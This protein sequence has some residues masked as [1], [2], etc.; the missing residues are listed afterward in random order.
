MKCNF[1]KHYWIISVAHDPFY[2]L[3]FLGKTAIKV[4]KDYKRL[5]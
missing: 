4:F 3:Q 1:K 2:T 5:T